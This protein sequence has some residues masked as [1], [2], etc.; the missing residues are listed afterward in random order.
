MWFQSVFKSS[1]CTGMNHVSNIT[2]STELTLTSIK[3]WLCVVLG[4]SNKPE[5]HTGLW[6]V[7]LCSMGKCVL[8]GNLKEVHDTADWSNQASLHDVLTQ[9]RWNLQV[10]SALL[11][12]GFKDDTQTGH[13]HSEL[14]NALH[15]TKVGMRDHRLEFRNNCL[16][17]YCEHIVR[18]WA[19]KGRGEKH[20]ATSPKVFAITRYLWFWSFMHDINLISRSHPAHTGSQGQNIPG[21]CSD[22][23][24]WSESIETM[25]ADLGNFSL[26][27][28]C[29]KTAGDFKSY[30]LWQEFGHR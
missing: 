10:R 15:R 12:S 18:R 29:Y 7:N 24:A 20:D 11:S 27:L 2:T 4:G 23:L 5:S 26:R 16:V 1:V 28:A 22:N 6:H 25:Q 3:V 19:G 17:R 21:G 9:A 14:T 8:T 30:H 13:C